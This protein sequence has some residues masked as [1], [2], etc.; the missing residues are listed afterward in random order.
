M[1]LSILSYIISII[2]F[3]ISK[4]LSKNKLKEKSNKT[5][6]NAITLIYNDINKYKGQNLLKNT[7][8]T[9]I[10]G[11]LSEAVFYTFYLVNDDAQILKLY[12]LNMYLIFQ[13]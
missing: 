10:F 7:L 8:I 2:P 12:S 6:E 1:Y 13:Y 3:F 5:Q 11:F 4:Y 9:S